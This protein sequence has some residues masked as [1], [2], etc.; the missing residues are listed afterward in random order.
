MAALTKDRNTQRREGNMFSLGVAA[1]KKIF[2]GS[3]VCKDA[4]G[5]ATPGAVATTLKALGRAEEQVDNTSG[6][7]GD[8]SVVIQPGTFK[9]A[10]SGGGDAIADA[11]IGNLCYVV[12]DQTVAK[13]DGTSTRSAAGRIVQVD[14]DGVWVKSG[15]D[16][17]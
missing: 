16:V 12:D 7:N 9:W 5:F 6:S 15:P 1:A 8:V 10:N 14:S 17:A 3:L 11:D 4:N 13:T 2:A